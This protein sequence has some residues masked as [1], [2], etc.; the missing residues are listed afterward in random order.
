MTLWEARD[1]F[2]NLQLPEGD[3]FIAKRLLHEIRSRL[4][5]LDEVGLGYLT[6]DRLSSTLSGGESQRVTLATQL[7]SSLVGSLY[8]LDEPSIGLHQRDTERLIRVV[9]RLRDLGNTVVV[10]EH[11]EEMMRAADYI[12]DIGPDAGRY[13]GEVVYAGPASE[14]TKETPGYTAAYLTGRETIPLPSAAPS[15][16]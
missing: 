12:I 3:A 2:D 13:G 9:H 7:G 10:V 8:V 4:T 14:I 6:L 11:D 1:F 5:F 15:M 16:E